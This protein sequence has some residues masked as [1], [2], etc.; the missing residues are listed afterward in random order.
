MVSRSQQ[1]P[2]YSFLLQ[3]PTLLPTST[4]HR[5][6]TTPSANNTFTWSQQ[7][8]MENVLCICTLLFCSSSA[9]HHWQINNMQCTLYV[10]SKV[11]CYIPQTVIVIAAKLSSSQAFVVVMKE[12]TKSCKGMTPVLVSVSVFPSAEWCQCLYLHGCV[13]APAPPTVHWAADAV[14]NLNINPWS[15]QGPL[16]TAGQF[17]H[18]EC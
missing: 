1:Q 5:P 6:L 8:R 13:P 7:G 2:H 3:F 18:I 4:G 16:C 14:Y 9:N 17:V 12:K 15:N 10:L 11:R